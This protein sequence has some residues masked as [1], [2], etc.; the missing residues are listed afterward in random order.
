M[1][2]LFLGL[3]GVCVVGGGGLRG[4]GGVVFIQVLGLTP[5]GV[6][7]HQ[8]RLGWGA[9]VGEGG[10]GGSDWGRVGVSEEM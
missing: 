4:L 9:G 6:D 10:R 2:W 7:I 5:F 1:L 8:K 3:G